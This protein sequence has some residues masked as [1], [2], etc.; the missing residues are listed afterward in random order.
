MVEEWLARREPS[1]I[2]GVEDESYAKVLD[3][4]CLHLLPRLGEWDLAVEFIG[5]ETELPQERRQVGHYFEKT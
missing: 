3:V 2:P 4:Y 5:Y 1:V